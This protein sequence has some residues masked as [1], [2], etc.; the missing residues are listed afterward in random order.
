MLF[1]NKMRTKC[2]I[3]ARISGSF[4]DCLLIIAQMAKLS[5]WKLI[6][7]FLSFAEKMQMITSMGYSSNMVMSLSTHC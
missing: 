3:R 4:D 1:C 6:E 5:Q 2:R 7:E